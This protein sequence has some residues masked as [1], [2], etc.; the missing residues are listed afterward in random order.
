MKLKKRW[1]IIQDNG[2]KW[3]S[4]SEHKPTNLPDGWVVQCIFVLS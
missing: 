4:Y 2:Y 3:A 1:R